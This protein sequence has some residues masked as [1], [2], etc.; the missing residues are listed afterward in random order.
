MCLYT[1]FAIKELK[2]LENNT[3]LQDVFK[4]DTIITTN[5]RPTSKYFQH[6]KHG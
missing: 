5:H 2:C 4:N 3:T 1:K 6:V